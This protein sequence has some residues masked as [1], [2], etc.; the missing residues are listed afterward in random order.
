MAQFKVHFPQSKAAMLHLAKRK[1]YANSK[2]LNV[3]SILLIVTMTARRFCSPTCKT[4]SSAE[5]NDHVV[6]VTSINRVSPTF[7]TVSTFAPI[8]TF[9]RKA[10]INETTKWLRTCPLLCTLDCLCTPKRLHPLLLESF[11][12]TRW[13]CSCAG[14]SGWSCRDSNP[15][16]LEP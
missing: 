15:V 9:G 16:P 7:G 1:Q 11:N 14:Q 13:M 5:R 2:K 6:K 10:G 12:S 3:N 8:W 4:L